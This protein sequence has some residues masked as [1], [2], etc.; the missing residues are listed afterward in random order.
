[1]SEP[2]LDQTHIGFLFEQ[3]GAKLWRNV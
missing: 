1:M 2:K 3:V